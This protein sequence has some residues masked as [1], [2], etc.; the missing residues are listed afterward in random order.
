MKPHSLLPL[1]LILG[2]ALLSACAS[3]HGR[4]QQQQDMLELPNAPLALKVQPGQVLTFMAKGTGV[5]IYQCEADA[6]TPGQYKWA[7]KAPEAELVNSHGKTLGKHYGGPTWEAN[8]GSK[9]IG[10]TV[11][12]DKDSD[13]AAIPWLLLSATSNSGTGVFSKT[14]SIQRLY[15]VSGKAP[16]DGCDQAHVG[17][18][19]RVTYTAQYYFYN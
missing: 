14:T 18:E 8:D 12:S 5:Q 16:A 10:K 3:R 17:T 6:N 15:T 7:F 19:S 11:A 13:P 4:H 2:A 1:T 9:V